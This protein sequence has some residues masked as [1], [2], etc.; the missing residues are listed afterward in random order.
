LYVF[1]DGI[2]IW[3]WEIPQ[4]TTQGC[5]NVSA[6]HFY[7]AGFHSPLNRHK[8]ANW[9]QLVMVSARHLLQRQETVADRDIQD[10]SWWS[11]STPRYLIFFFF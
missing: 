2:Q 6:T 7:F 3:L 9:N 11:L 5:G 10:F 8:L 1:I 4:V